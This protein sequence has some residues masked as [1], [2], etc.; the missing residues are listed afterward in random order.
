[1]SSFSTGLYGSTLSSI[2]SNVNDAFS[3]KTSG[4]DVSSVVS[5][6]MQVEDQPEVQMQ[7]QHALRRCRHQSGLTDKKLL[8]AGIRR[9][10]LGT[11]KRA[12]ILLQ[13]GKIFV[14]LEAFL[15]HAA[16]NHRSHP[17]IAQGKG[18]DPL[19]GRL[20]VPQEERLWRRRRFGAGGQRHPQQQ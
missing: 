1:M 10:D 6:L 15:R 14:E 16:E 20:A 5:E 11:Q 12:D 3:G 9:F 2:V 18:F 19:G 17:A 13:I 7:N 8:A 4:I